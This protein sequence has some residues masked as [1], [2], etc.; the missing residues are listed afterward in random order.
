MASLNDGVVYCISELE[1]GNTYIGQSMNM[2]ARISHHK[3][4]LFKNKSIKVEELVK[5]S[6]VDLTFWEYFYYCKYQTME[7]IKLLNKRTPCFSSLTLK[8]A[9]VDSILSSYI[10]FK[11]L[12]IDNGVSI[13][14]SV[15]KNIEI[16]TLVQKQYK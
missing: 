10:R 6:I 8:L 14:K 4:N 7:G 2:A 1:T 12:C 16:Y 3:T 15:K 5:C 13:P 11:E 9:N